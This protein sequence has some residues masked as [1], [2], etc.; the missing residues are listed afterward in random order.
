VLVP[1]ATTLS[2]LEV[3]V[4]EHSECFLPEQ[5]KAV[6]IQFQ[7]NKQEKCKSQQ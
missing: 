7:E 6:G 4:L 1:N 5:L 2:S 3:Y